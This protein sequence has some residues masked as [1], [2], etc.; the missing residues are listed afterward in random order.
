MASWSRLPALLVAG[1]AALSLVASCAEEPHEDDHGEAATSPAHVHAL[2]INPADDT[3]Y[4]ASHDGLFR[5]TGDGG[6]EQVARRTQD[7]MG[8]A[9]AGPDRFLG[10]GHPGP[11]DTDQPS[12]LGLIESTDAGQTWH[13][14]SLAGEA[15]FHALEVEH[16]RVYGYDSVSGTL[17]VSDDGKTWDRRAEVG[18]ADLAVSPDDAERIVV[19]TE[20]GPAHS[21][22]GGRGFAPAA[23]GPVLVFLDWPS[24]GR[25]LG[26]G[27][28]GTVHHSADGGHTWQ[29]RGR[30]PGRPQAIT[31]HGESE[32]YVAAESGIY[33]STD[34]GRTFTLLRRL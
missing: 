25:L 28:D 7:F 2:A 12:H 4:V 26:I 32:V 30:V 6:A 3:L 9:I 16:D 20:N 13:S 14:L 29:P 10:S 23:G 15:D 22:D 31:T 17:M 24:A 19:T 33:H 11:H 18:I 34:D 8:F 5:V 27:T 1:A 21:T